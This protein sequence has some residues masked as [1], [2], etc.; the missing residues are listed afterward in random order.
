MRKRIFLAALLHDIG[1]FYQRADKPL[2]SRN[3][4]SPSVTQM[5]DY[6]CP[7]DYYGNYRYQ[8][9][10]WT[11][12]FLTNIENQLQ[13][14]PTFEDTDFSE[15]NKR[16][17]IFALAASHHKPSTKLQALITLADWWSAGSDRREDENRSHED[18]TTSTI[19]WGIGHDT[20]RKIPLFSI[21]NQINKDKKSTN[22]IA[23]KL[24]PLSIEEKDFF[25]QAVLSKEDGVSE[26][27][28]A[29]L[30]KM[31]EEEVAS[32]PTSSFQAYAESLISLLKKYSWCIPSSTIDMAN[33]SLFDHLK[34][35]AA[36]ADCLYVYTKEHEDS[37]TYEGKHI[38]INDGHYPVLLVG[39]DLSGIQK[40]IYNIASR[41]AANS[42]KGR[43][44]YLQLL[45]D[46][47]V[48][49]IIRHHDIMASS[50]HIV[51]SAG[52]KFYMLLP[53]T[54]KVKNALQE[55]KDL[56][57]EELFEKHQGQLIFNIDY[58]PFNYNTTRTTKPFET[59]IKGNETLE[60]GQLWQLLS[61]K[62]T[63]LKTKPF[64]GYI[65]NYYDELFN[66]Q[67]V[68]TKEHVCAVTG[69][70]SKNCVI[71]DKNVESS[72][73][74]R[75]LPS[76]KEQVELGRSLKNV[77]YI[78]TYL[79]QYEVQPYLEKKASAEIEIGG[80]KHYLISSD[81]EIT[82]IDNCNIS[83]I[84]NTNFINTK[85]KNCQYS[86]LFY[87]GNKQAINNKEENKTFEELSNGEY[88]GILRMDVDNLGA[89]F[90]NGLPEKNKSFS[91]NATLSF[92]L[93]YFF[94]GYLNTIREKYKDD[95]NILYS[96]GDDVFAIGK[97]NKLIEFAKD[98]R[99]DFEKFVGRPDIS[100]S[101]G[102]AL[103]G[104]KFPIAKGAE[105]AGEAEDAAKKGN[106]GQKNAFNLFGETI[107]WG[108]EFNF[109]E[110]QKNTMVKLCGKAISKGFLHKLQQYSMLAKADDLQYLWHTTY[111]LSRY[112][113]DRKENQATTQY[114][115]MLRD[116]ILRNKK[117][118]ILMGIAARWAELELRDWNQK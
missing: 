61:E 104:N 91:A 2:N 102:I 43:S 73:Q 23:F 114:C 103:V 82:S 83:S 26:F 54:Q 40:F 115:T 109:V 15:E 99:Y 112:M 8:H 111:F 59:N 47:I 84:N 118:F 37:F 70:E 12:Q 29:T 68:N 105:L 98:I 14:I 21:F 31:F 89:I 17:S 116:K 19:D 25:P 18:T 11:L 36:F 33:V 41:K 9:T 48:Q 81:N 45:I 56:L 88:L 7:Q 24:K 77:A 65:K 51:Y 46:S 16:N 94:S 117:D 87:G 86:F 57:D 3:D 22:N 34:T 42:L 110:E 78:A 113:K 100:I 1:K 58:I 49:Q 107:T 76:V 44:F 52:G 10:I 6:I 101:G 63:A 13:Q 93:D 67:N 74:I 4:L 71:L 5:V 30:W 95:V 32:L 96:G 60:I 90:I 75:V 35:T 28:Y 55:I 20:F 97:W 106:N 92:M 62:L 38:K 66:P 50:A 80:Y 64:N 79:I 85:G 27:Q 69:I 108:K 39:G 72:K 53:N